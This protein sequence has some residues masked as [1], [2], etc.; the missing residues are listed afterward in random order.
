MSLLLNKCHLLTACQIHFTYNNSFN[1]HNNPSYYYYSSY[2][3]EQTVAQRGQVTR[4]R[5]EMMRQIKD[6]YPG[7]SALESALLASA[8]DRPSET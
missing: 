5:T 6:P 2:T 3:G 7:I 8:L 1:H 4:L